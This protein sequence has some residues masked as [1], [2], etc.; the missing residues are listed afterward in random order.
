MSVAKSLRM[1]FA[2]AIVA[3]MLAFPAGATTLAR[4]GLEELVA[5]NATVVVGQVMDV[6]SYWND[7][8][9][10]IL[11]D[12][13]LATSETLKGRVRNGEVTV[14]LMGGTVGGTTTLIVGGPQLFEGGTYVLFLNRESLPGKNAVT[15]RDHVQGVFQVFEGE[16]GQRA[17]SQANSH[18]LVPDL[19][20]NTEPPGGSAGLALSELTHQIRV[21]ERSARA[22]QN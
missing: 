5:S 16:G 18:P 8:G 14:T 15:V 6:F 1:G 2:A 9:T 7:E 20:G 21:I 11:T 3:A 10:F 12:V 19:F 4:V 22:L 17:V 13:R